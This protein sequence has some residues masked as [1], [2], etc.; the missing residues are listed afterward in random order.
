MLTQDENESNESN[1]SND[2]S[3][4]NSSSSNEELLSKMDLKRAERRLYRNR[5]RVK[6]RV[7]ASKFFDGP[8]E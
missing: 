4:E 6:R 2:E 8:R 3:D 1:E 7:I 5:Q